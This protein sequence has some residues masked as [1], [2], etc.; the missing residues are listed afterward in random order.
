MT[1]VPYG[2]SLDIDFQLLPPSEGGRS[3]P[4]KSG[5]RPLCRFT[6]PDGQTTTVGMCQLELGA[7]DHVMPGDRGAGSLVFVEDVAALVRSLAS[8]GTQLDLAEGNRVVG[9]ATV[10]GVA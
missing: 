2:V 7:A 4:V 3:T 9:H 1:E 5:Y 6:A 10:R 8:A